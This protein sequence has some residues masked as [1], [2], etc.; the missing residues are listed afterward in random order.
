[1]TNVSLSRRKTSVAKWNAANDRQTLTGRRSFLSAE[2][3]QAEGLFDFRY[4]VEEFPSEELEDLVHFFTITD[5]LYRLRVRLASHVAIACR[6]L[7]DR[8]LQLELLYDFAGRRS[9]IS[10]T[11]SAIAASERP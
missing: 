4:G 10:P 9:K 5:D 6:R 7:I 1:M 2:G 8:V 11:F 3:L